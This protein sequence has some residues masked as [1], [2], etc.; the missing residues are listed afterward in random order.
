[1]GGDPLLVFLEDTRR[2]VDWKHRV[3]LTGNN[4]ITPL[5]QW[6]LSR[7]LKAWAAFA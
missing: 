2:P 1:M 7:V 5:T 3:P 6:K 4:Q